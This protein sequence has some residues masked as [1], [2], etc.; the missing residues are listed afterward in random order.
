MAGGAALI[1]PFASGSPSFVPSLR[2]SRP[3]E[4]QAQ[5]AKFPAL[6]RREL[7]QTY[8]LLREFGPGCR[9]AVDDT[10]KTPCK[11]PDWER[12]RVQ[13]FLLRLVARSIQ[14]DRITS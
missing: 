1:L 3:I 7:E 11:V 5:R 8:N 10:R 13:Q 9:D 14:Q 4:S 6:W 12:L 2:S